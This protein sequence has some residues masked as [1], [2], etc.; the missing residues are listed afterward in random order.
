M[1][2]FRKIIRVLL[3]AYLVYI[4]GRAGWMKI[5]ENDSMMEGM[6]FFGFDRAATL[7]IGY[8]EIITLLVLLLGVQKHRIRNMA[9]LVLL[10][11]AFGALMVH[12]AH[13]DYVDH[14]D[15]LFCS[16][17]AM[18]CLGLDPYFGIRV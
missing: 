15:A 18:S 14:Y 16:I 2:L 3:Y 9:T 7:A 5:I 4:F 11:F 12:W 17:A 1:Q 13:R 8:A 10:L 6:R